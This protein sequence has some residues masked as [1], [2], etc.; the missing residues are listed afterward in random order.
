MGDLQ[1]S[2]RTLKS[3]E[4]RHER[5]YPDVQ[6][7]IGRKI[8]PQGSR[9]ATSGAFAFSNSVFFPPQFSFQGFLNKLFP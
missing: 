8:S 4:R 2:L 3:V 1:D 5:D 9:C 7:V 6:M